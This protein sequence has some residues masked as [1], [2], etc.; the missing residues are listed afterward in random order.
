MIV[1]VWRA[2]ALM[3]QLGARKTHL[4]GG[5]DVA[6]QMERQVQVQQAASG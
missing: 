5:V 2:V 3:G 4:A 6:T 1:K